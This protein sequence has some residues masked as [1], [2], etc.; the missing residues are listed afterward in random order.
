MADATIFDTDSA[1]EKKNWKSPEAIA[2]RR[3]RQDL[4]Y[5]RI[6]AKKDAERATE[7]LVLGAGTSGC[8]LKPEY[9]CAI[10][11]EDTAINALK[12]RGKS[13]VS[14]LV[15][16]W[17][18]MEDEWRQF[19]VINEVDPYEAFTVPI[20]GTCAANV[21]RED[22]VS[23][24]TYAQSVLDYSLDNP[25]DHRKQLG[26]LHQLI[27]EYGGLDFIEACK[28]EQGIDFQEL[29]RALTPIVHGIATM[30]A[31]GVY[32]RDVK[33]G[34]MMFDTSSRTGKLIDYG[35]VVNTPKLLYEDK[36]LDHSYEVWPPEC[37]LLYKEQYKKPRRLA[38]TDLANYNIMALL[39][40]TL[41]FLDFKKNQ[42]VNMDKQMEEKVTSKVAYDDRY[43]AT[44]L[45]AETHF[46]DKFDI[47]SLGIAVAT[48]VLKYKQMGRPCYQSYKLTTWIR[49]TI[50]YNAFARWNAATAAANWE[51]VMHAQ[52][53]GK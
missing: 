37:D 4:V 5:K 30:A 12:I 52:N 27:A 16:S 40:D 31:M 15:G 48:L 9:S 24:C 6:L 19:K 39:Y 21:K 28:P 49:H 42:I 11:E 35:Y 13:Y 43:A 44:K 20:L 29:L 1:T 14:K 50:D 32:H 41:S 8:V 46:A 2:E 10:E 53:M 45:Y 33:L 22:I 17:E 38:N 3:R 7:H 47:Y 18:N 34:N 25:K 26:Q 51:E 23:K 36:I